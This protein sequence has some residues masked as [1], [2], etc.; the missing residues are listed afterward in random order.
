MALQVQFTWSW[1]RPLTGPSPGPDQSKTRSRRRSRS[2]LRSPLGA[3]TEQP[4]PL[5]LCPDSQFPALPESA[6]GTSS[7]PAQVA[8]GRGLAVSPLSKSTSDKSPWPKPLRMRFSVPPGIMMHRARCVASGAGHPDDKPASLTL[9]AK[10]SEILL[11]H[12]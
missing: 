4:R 10:F 2:M 6:G 12:L 8:L 5:S 1:G 7:I 11:L 3:A 9:L